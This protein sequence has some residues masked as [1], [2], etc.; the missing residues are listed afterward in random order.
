MPVS[1]SGAFLF[2]ANR[3]A[4]LSR[5]GI[6]GMRAHGGDLSF[7]F[8]DAIIITGRRKI[9]IPSSVSFYLSFFLATAASVPNDKA[10]SASWPPVP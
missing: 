9:V 2:R 4:H 5:D 1:P 3:P 8:D 10:A 6:W 7:R